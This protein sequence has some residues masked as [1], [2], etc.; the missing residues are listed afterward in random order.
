MCHKIILNFLSK[1]SLQQ[2]QAHKQTFLTPA[3]DCV[4]C[5]GPQ[6]LGARETPLTFVTLHPK[7]N[8]QKLLDTHFINVN[9][10]RQ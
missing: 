2:L 6:A 5:R 8:V 7:Q 4:Q 3:L 9:R 10:T 1:E